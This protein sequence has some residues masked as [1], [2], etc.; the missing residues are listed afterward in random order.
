MGHKVEVEAV[1]WDIWSSKN[2]EE[3]PLVRPRQQ[4]V[5]PAAAG[6]EPNSGE[7]GFP[8]SGTSAASQA[9]RPGWWCRSARSGLFATDGGG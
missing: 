5:V 2:M 8:R 1:E 3:R 4:A 6:S 7:L 9:N